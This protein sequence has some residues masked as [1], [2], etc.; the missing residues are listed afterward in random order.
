MLLSPATERI[1]NT[2]KRERWYSSFWYS[3]GFAYFGE[4]GDGQRQPTS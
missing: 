2:V 1:G 4:S 3:T